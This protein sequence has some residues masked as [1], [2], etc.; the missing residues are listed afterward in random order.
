MR[1]KLGFMIR[2]KEF[3]KNQ[4]KEK[5]DYNNLLPEKDLEMG[6]RTRSVFI[7]NKNIEANEKSKD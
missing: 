3:I 6:Y 7:D 5:I 2:Q 1:N 4:I